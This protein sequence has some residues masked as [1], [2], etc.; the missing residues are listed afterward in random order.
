[1]GFQNVI[2][3]LYP[4]LTSNRT[5]SKSTKQPLGWGCRSAS[6]RQAIGATPVTVPIA[7]RE[8]R[9]FCVGG[10]TA[11][12]HDLEPPGRRGDPTRWLRR[13][14]HGEVRSVAN[15]Q[16]SDKIA[17]GFGSLV[18]RLEKVL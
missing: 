2:K 4:L 7:A 10:R 14:A 1:M 9:R 17:W 12:P 3:D 16:R 11:S 6:L 15:S 8:L 13:Q 18:L 5:S